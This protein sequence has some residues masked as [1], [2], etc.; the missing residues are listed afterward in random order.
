[1]M[2]NTGA[3]LSFSQ[4]KLEDFESFKKAVLDEVVGAVYPLHRKVFSLYWNNSVTNA[5]PKVCSYADYDEGAF[6]YSFPIV[7]DGGLVHHVFS[8][9][10]VPE[11]TPGKFRAASAEARIK[12]MAYMEE[13]PGKVGGITTYT[14]A[15]HYE[16][17][18]RFKFIHAINDRRTGECSI[19]VI[20]RNPKRA[21]L[22]V[23][24]WWAS[25]LCSRL[26][27]LV[28]ELS[29]KLGLSPW[30][31]HPNLLER[32]LSSDLEILDR[33][34]ELDGFDGF[35]G[36]DRAGRAGDAGWA[37]RPLGGALSAPG[38]GPLV[39]KRGVALR[40]A[41]YYMNA[42]YNRVHDLCSRV[43]GALAAAMKC[44]YDTVRHL[45][46]EIERLANEV[47]REEVARR[48]ARAVVPVVAPAVAQAAR[49][50]NVAEVVR[51]VDEALSAARSIIIEWAKGVF[52]E[53][54]RSVAEGF[55]AKYLQARPV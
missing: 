47:L 35:D 1:M 28:S 54:R 24:R 11:L 36:L 23:L 25:F 39:Q 48:V 44:L 13:P 38:P 52:L 20:E 42:L 6:S 4:A 46:N 22:T 40:N 19:P 12:T 49:T 32:L 17:F 7:Y 30:T 10:V 16:R 31:Y 34:D 18:A 3:P 43:C 5:M 15:P 53:V 45:L 21:A 29:R 37:L 26:D 27:G 50:G 33:L 14:V 9:K 55:F 8:V 2:G 41:L 51:R